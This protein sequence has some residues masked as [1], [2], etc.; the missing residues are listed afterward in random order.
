MLKII[1]VSKKYEKEILNNVN[2]EVKKGEIIGIVGANGSG[3]STLLSIIT[4]NE[5]A[6]K[7]IVE[8]G[9]TM[10]YVPQENILFEK[11]SIKENLIFWSEANNIKKESNFFS[12]SYLSKKVCSLSGGNKKLVNIDIGL[13]NDPEYLIM[14]EPTSPLD[15]V[16]KNKVMKLIADRKAMGKSV[17]FTSHNIDE[18]KI[19]D[20]VYVVRNGKV[21]PYESV[22]NI[23]R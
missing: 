21:A 9:G 19:C 22:K 2:I 23:V 12:E 13:I 8:V 14:D 17:I 11:L 1:G 6:D 15:I 4:G 20:K 3:K 7:G 10:N 5:K 18:I 16:N